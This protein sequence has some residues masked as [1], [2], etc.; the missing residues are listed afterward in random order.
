MEDPDSKNKRKLS[1]VSEKSVLDLIK[2]DDSSD[3]ENSNHERLVCKVCNKV[4]IFY[5]VMFFSKL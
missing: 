4:F 3:D 1:I 2:S 5:G